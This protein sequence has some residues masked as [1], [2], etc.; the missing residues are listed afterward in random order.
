MAKKV[1][2]IDEIA[3]KWAD[4][5]PG[6]ASY[7]EKYAS[8][9]GAD[10]E[11]GA[12]GA[13]AAFKAAVTAPGIDAH[14][15]GGVKKVGGTKYERKVKAVGVGRFGP[16]VAAAKDDMKSG[17]A[18]HRD[19]IETTLPTLKARG[20]RGDPAN[21]DRSKTIGTALAKKRLALIAASPS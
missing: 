15:A 7:Y 6:R 1:K 10:W 16:G 20:P 13:R 14:Y 9:A 4:V 19:E 18:P 2:S 12:T 3:A 11:T 17:F 8:V 5:T 21:W